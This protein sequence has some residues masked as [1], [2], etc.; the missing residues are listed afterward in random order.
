MNSSVKGRE[1]KWMKKVP[2]QVKGNGT[3]SFWDRW[4]ELNAL[5]SSVFLSLPYD[6]N[7]I[8]AY[9]SAF[10]ASAITSS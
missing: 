9:P 4:V 7:F 1:K 8:Y 10:F 3:Y 2:S 6:L 5:M